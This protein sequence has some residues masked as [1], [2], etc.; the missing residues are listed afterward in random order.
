VVTDAQWLTH[1]A[2]WSF[3]IA[4]LAYLAFALQL[5]ARWRGD[6]HSSLLLGFV[7]LSAFWAATSALF[8]GL[9]TPGMWFSERLFDALRMLVALA[10]LSLVLGLGRTVENNGLRYT[11]R[12][13]LVA[14]ASD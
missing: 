12:G 2:T 4:A 1:P 5:S 8:V 7:M 9:Q 11:V 10:F 14:I 6:W 3:G 13:V